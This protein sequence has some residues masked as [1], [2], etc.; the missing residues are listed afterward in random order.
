MMYRRLTARSFILLLFCSALAA[1]DE[2]SKSKFTTKPPKTAKSAS[3]VDMSPVPADEKAEA[4]ALESLGEGFEIKRTQHYSVI[5]DTSDADAGAFATAIEGTYRSCMN[6]VDKLQIPSFKPRKKLIIYYFE[7]H[8]DYSAHAVKLKRGERPQNTPGVYFPDLNLSMFYNF[9]NQDSFRQAREQAKQQVAQL[10]EQLR[11]AVTPDQRRQIGEQIKKAQAQANFSGQKGGDL[12]E[13]IVQHEVAHQVL[14][15]IGFHNR[16]QV[17]ANPRWFAEGTAM[18]FE[19]LSESGSANIG[20]VN[21]QRLD[22]YR[23]CLVGKQLIPTADF[24]SDWKYFAPETIH[25][26]YAQSWAM[27]HYLNRVKRKQV[28]DYVALLNKR[29]KDFKTTPERELADFQKCFGKLDAR[30]DKAWKAWMEKV[31]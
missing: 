16:K 8:K 21:T 1:A 3:G 23:Q 13:T 26:A 6:Y 20:K 5:Y 9:A 4:M 30:W 28:K 10:K 24:V 27:V 25:I 29:P 15:N 14:W 2:P 12:S 19:P 17:W 31:R 11:G 7:H 18:M 22:E